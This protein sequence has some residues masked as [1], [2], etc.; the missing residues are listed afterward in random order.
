MTTVDPTDIRRLATACP[1]FVA[2]LPRFKVEG[3]SG[4]HGAFGSM[5]QMPGFAHRETIASGRFHQHSPYVHFVYL[6]D[7]ASFSALSA[8]V[9]VFIGYQS[10]MGHEL[11]VRFEA[12]KV[13]QIHQDGGRSDCVHPAQRYQILSFTSNGTAIE[14]L[15]TFFTNGL[16]PRQSPLYLVHVFVEDDLLLRIGEALS[17]ELT[18]TCLGPMTAS[19][20]YAAMMPKQAVKP[21]IHT[22]FGLL[23]VFA[24]TLQVSDGLLLLIRYPHR[25]QFFL[26]VPS[27]L[28]ERVAPLRPDPVTETL[29][30]Q[31]HQ[32]AFMSQPPKTFIDDRP[33]SARA[34]LVV[35][36]QLSPRT[37]QFICQS[38]RRYARGL[39]RAIQ[40]WHLAALGNRYGDRV[41][42]Y[43]HRTE[44]CSFMHSPIFSLREQVLRVGDSSIDNPCIPRTEETFQVNTQGL[45]ETS[46]Q[47]RG[48]K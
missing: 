48:N 16:D 32:G 47:S 24:D 44:S 39:N 36:P 29:R 41:F 30:I 5:L 40:H 28:V 33:V 37:S 42:L 17:Q 11:T 25:G 46:I 2:E 38:L 20:E 10:D 45:I 18:L 21:L 15:F 43:Y 4:L 34:C 19:R 22:P 8:E 9:F 7:R 35:E 3:Q 1:L 31:P 27:R 26:P 23:D 12:G 13:S 14:R 6:G